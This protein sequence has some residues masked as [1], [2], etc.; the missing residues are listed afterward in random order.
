M[1]ESPRYLIENG[2]IE[3]AKKSLARVNKVSAEDQFVNDEVDVIYTALET[4]KLAGSASWGE[5]FT[6]KPKIFYRLF[7]GVML[8]SLQ[9]LTG[10]NYFFYYGTTIFKS[11]GLEDS[12]ETSIILG[13]V[14]FA[15]TFVAFYIMDK[16]GRRKVLLGGAASIW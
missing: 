13:I 6:G 14:N 16:L 10:N 7:V 8:Q 15:S 4:E 12:Y 3:E 2:K 11:V 5:L 9:Q 1:P